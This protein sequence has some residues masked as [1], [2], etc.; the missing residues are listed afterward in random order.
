MEVDPPH[1]G[2]AVRS[3][4]LGGGHLPTPAGRTARR[5]GGALA[6]L[7]FRFPKNK[8]ART[9][10]LSFMNF[11]H[12]LGLD[13]LSGKCKVSEKLRQKKHPVVAFGS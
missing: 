11:S 2:V 4:D 6:G 5:Q 9:H 1:L 3:H 13:H 7:C 12:F 8:S 10:F